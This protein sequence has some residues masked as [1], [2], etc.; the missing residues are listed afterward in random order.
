MRLHVETNYAHDEQ[1]R[2]IGVNQWDGGAVPRFWL[3]R[4]RAGHV[5]R[6]RADVGEALITALTALCCAEPC[7]DALDALPRY[8]REYE[9]LLAG[10][11]PIVRRWSGPAYV[12]PVDSTPQRPA[13]ALT[14]QD[15]AR[16]LGGLEEWQPDLAHR[17]PIRAAL[18]DG[19]A[20]AICASVRIRA[21][22]HAAGVETVPSAQ[23]SGHACAVVAS[24]AQAVHAL[25]ARALY[26][27]SWDNGASRRVAAKLGAQLI[28]VDFHLE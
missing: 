3:G 11:A 17:Q 27:T 8:A 14:V 28:G 15:H 10:E 12:L 2:L 21:A 1:G 4:T 19:R 13:A 22:A 6:F 26:S 7:A 16:L 23:G 24:W 25:N 18:V 5:W 20:V 9:Q